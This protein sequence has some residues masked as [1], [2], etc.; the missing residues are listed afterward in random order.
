M[1][2]CCQIICIDTFIRR[3]FNSKSSKFK[4]CCLCKYIADPLS[5]NIYAFCSAYILATSFSWLV[6]PFS[7]LSCSNNMIFSFINPT[8]I[9]FTNAKSKHFAPVVIVPLRCNTPPIRSTEIFHF[10]LYTL[11][12][13]YH[14]S[15]F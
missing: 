6:N 14:N 8:S 10:I 13:L 1:F 2:S 15:H 3:R 12:S 11:S 7:L 9:L 4:C 5:I